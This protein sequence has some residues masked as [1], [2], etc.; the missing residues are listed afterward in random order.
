MKNL[1]LASFIIL[2][3]TSCSKDSF[4][5][6][7]SEFQAPEKSEIMVRVSYLDYSTNTC[8][9]G[10]VSQSPQMVVN[11]VNAKVDLY[12]GNQS[13]AMNDPIVKVR[14]DD[15]GSALIKDLEPSTYTIIVD[16]EFG[17]KFKTLATQL[18]RRSFV[19]FSF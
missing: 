6:D 10:C 1:I 16:T 7:N 9:P 13:D 15:D 11:I 12:E 17:I 8:E 4:E 3:L 18:G 5:L 2:G 19:D 14:T